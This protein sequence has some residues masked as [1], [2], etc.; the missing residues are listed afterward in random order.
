M[1]PAVRKLPWLLLNSNPLLTSLN[2]H[3][4]AI[5][6]L[7]F[8]FYLLFQ[9]LIV[10]WL[11]EL[12]Q[13]IFVLLIYFWSVDT[14]LLIIFGQLPDTV[15]PP[16]LLPPNFPHY[17]FLCLLRYTPGHHLVTSETSE[18]NTNHAQLLQPQTSLRLRKIQW[19]VEWVLDS[20]YF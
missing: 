5:S 17:T 9:I 11:S 19:W 2:I 6:K 16:P 13:L 14:G 15:S 10:F 3:K 7:S 1:K 4:L 12:R 20:I 8:S 18:P